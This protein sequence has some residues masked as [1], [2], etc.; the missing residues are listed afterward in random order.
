MQHEDK[1]RELLQEFK[2]MERREPLPST[3]DQYVES[4]DQ[5]GTDGNTRVC[6]TVDS[7]Y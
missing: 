6:S 1:E 5:I 3:G 2:R 7:G 4:V